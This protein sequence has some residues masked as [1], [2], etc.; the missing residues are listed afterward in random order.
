MIG[1]LKS[2]QIPSSDS[3]IKHYSVFA[4]DQDWKGD[5]S[6]TLDDAPFILITKQMVRLVGIFASSPKQYAETVFNNQTSSFLSGEKSSR[7]IA[8]SMAGITQTTWNTYPQI[9]HTQ[10]QD[11][12]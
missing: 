7:Q 5:L 8:A 2:S 3:D 1:I 11:P 12:V 4:F 6:L 9:S 10:T